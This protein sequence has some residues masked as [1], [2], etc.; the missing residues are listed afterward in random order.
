M[1]GTFRV[2]RDGNGLHCWATNLYSTWVVLCGCALWWPAAIGGWLCFSCCSP[3]DPLPESV[4]HSL[5]QQSLLTFTYF[6][7]H[8]I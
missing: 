6:F 2:F 8:K 1:R 3:V 5:R 4:E 7:L